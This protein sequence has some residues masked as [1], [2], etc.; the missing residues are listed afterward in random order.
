MS[1]GIN[2]VLGNQLHAQ[3]LD[4]LDFLL[5]NNSLDHIHSVA[6]E[7]ASGIGDGEQE[8]VGLDVFLGPLIEALRCD[9]AG[10][11]LASSFDSVPNALGHA[12]VSN[13]ECSQVGVSSQDVLSCGLCLLGIPVSVL[14]S[15]DFD[16][17]VS[18]QN[19]IDSAHTLLVSIASQNAFQN[20]DLAL[21]VQL[22]NQF[23]HQTLHAGVV[24]E[25][26]TL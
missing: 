6:G 2:V 12:V 23:F 9:L 19:F 5:V 26:Y 7:E 21:A 14:G 15:N 1:C 11:L 16:A 25:N 3:I 18:S 20:N 10:V 17:G 4:M 22:L 13:D 24:V 8:L